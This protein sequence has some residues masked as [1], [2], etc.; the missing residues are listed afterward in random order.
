MTNFEDAVKCYAHKTK[1][2]KKLSLSLEKGK[3]QAISL[4]MN[5]SVVL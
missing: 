3:C 1:Y 4:A 2:M 5:H